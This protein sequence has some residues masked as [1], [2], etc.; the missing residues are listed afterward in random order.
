MAS[1]LSPPYIASTPNLQQGEGAQTNQTRGQNEVAYALHHLL[2][3]YDFET[4]FQ[5]L[6]AEWSWYFLLLLPCSSC[7]T[8]KENKN[9]LL[10]HEKLSNQSM[11]AVYIVFWDIKYPATIDR[12]ALSATLGQN[13]LEELKARVLQLCQ[14]FL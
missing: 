6:R 3:F 11:D 8:S 12:K 9:Y 1:F 10:L 5:V 14:Q 13:T 7:F 4:E 2:I